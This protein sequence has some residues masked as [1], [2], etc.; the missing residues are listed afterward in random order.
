MTEYTDPVA[1]LAAVT[2]RQAEIVCEIERL[3]GE[4]KRTMPRA[5][6]TKG[7]PRKRGPYR[8]FDAVCQTPGCETHFTARR[9]DARYCSECRRERK[10]NLHYR[11]D[12]VKPKPVTIVK[13]AK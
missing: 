3:L 10:T 11:K 1:A 4:L 12:G 5:R 6:T 7:T 8:A 9:R 2:Q 13:G